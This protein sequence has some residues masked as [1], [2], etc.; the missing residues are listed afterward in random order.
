[1]ITPIPAMPIVQN[2]GAVCL[3]SEVT[4][5][6]GAAYPEGTIY[7]W[8]DSDPSLGTATMFSQ[9]TNPIINDITVAGT[10]DYWLTITINSCT[11]PAGKT[12]III[13]ELPTISA[14]NNG[15]EC[16]DPTTDLI[17]SSVPVSYTHLTLPTIYPV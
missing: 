15:S 14:M 3:G 16:V 10:Y 13:N 11:S 8:Y 2:S 1:M 7:N 4:L 5:L 12:S 6:A 17:I 9:E